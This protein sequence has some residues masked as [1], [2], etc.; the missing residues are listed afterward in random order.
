MSTLSAVNISKAFGGIAALDN[1]HVSITTGKI[2][3][4]IGENGAGKS[5]IIKTLNGIYKF[6]AGQIE[7]DGEVFKEWSGERAVEVGL[8]TIHQEILLV[9][10]LS[11]Y[12]NVTLGQPQTKT[13]YLPKSF[14]AV[15]QEKDRD[16]AI[17]IL[18][19]LGVSEGFD[20]VK[21][22][23]LSPGKAQMILIARA[24]S[25]SAKF[26]IL[27]EPTAALPH[28]ERVKF[29][30]LISFLAEHGTGIL[31]VSHHLEEV[32]SLCSEVFVFR[33]GKNVAKLSGKEINIKNMVNNMLARELSEQYKKPVNNPDQIK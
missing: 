20:R 7:L 31:L 24:I 4:L 10:E 3:G 2:T 8:S 33:D 26:L 29:F 13:K 28:N 21:A 14:R 12:Q 25:R 17:E 23:S 5:T 11:V 9:P 18:Q 16:I 27:D 6:D 30:E 1:A 15:N 22:G 32:E 19:K